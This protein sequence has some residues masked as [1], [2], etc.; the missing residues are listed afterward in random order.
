MIERWETA[1]QLTFDAAALPSWASICENRSTFTKPVS[2]QIS[3]HI[4]HVG[5]LSKMDLL[6]ARTE[7]FI[8]HQGLEKLEAS[9]YPESFSSPAQHKILPFNFLLIF[10]SDGYL[11]FQVNFA[12]ILHLFCSPIDVCS[13]T[14]AGYWYQAN[15]FEAS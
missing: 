10:Y 4:S 5:I 12:F 1:G 13:A 7:P 9:T 3:S 6:M 8:G 15:Q 11:R 2:L 14:K